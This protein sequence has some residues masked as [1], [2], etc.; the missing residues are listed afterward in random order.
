MEKEVPLKVLLLCN[1]DLERFLLSYAS[2]NDDDH[3]H[4]HDDVDELLCGKVDQ[5]KAITPY[6]QPVT[7]SEI[8]TISNLQ[9]DVSSLE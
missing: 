9:Q 3:D 6:F 1:F 2:L 8:R 7:L 5:R 4:D